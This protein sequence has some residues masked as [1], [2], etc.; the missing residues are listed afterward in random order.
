MY[1][2]VWIYLESERERERKR[3]SVNE[4]KRYISVYRSSRQSRIESE[5]EYGEY[6]EQTAN[7]CVNLD[8][9]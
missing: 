8:E 6:W 3:K 1:I 4:S 7:E 2:C 9:T 5:S